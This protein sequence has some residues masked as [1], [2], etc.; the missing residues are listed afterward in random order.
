V[1]IV[2]PAERRIGSYVADL[3]P[4][5]ATIQIGIGQIPATIGEALRDKR[6]LGVHT[7]VFTDVVAD[8]VEAGAVTGARKEVNPGKIVA[9][10]VLGSQRLYP[11][12]G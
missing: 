11:I 5:G 2:T 3:V 9:T 10:F 8:L 6:D 4:H 1:R 7:K 12:R